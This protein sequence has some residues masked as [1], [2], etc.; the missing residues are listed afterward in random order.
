[1]DA[2]VLHAPGCGCDEVADVV[3]RARREIRA[4]VALVAGGAARTVRISNL[5]GAEHAAA[6]GVA[7]AQASGVAMKIVRVERGAPLVVIG[8]RL[9]A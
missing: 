4:G 3:A 6:E 1:M 2:H 9:D 5:P 7:V 8:P